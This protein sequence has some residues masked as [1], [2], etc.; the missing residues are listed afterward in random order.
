MATG[1][2]FDIK[3]MAIYDGPGIRTTDF[4][5]GCPLRCMWSRS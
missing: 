3:Q 2:V 5:K 1:T 4:L